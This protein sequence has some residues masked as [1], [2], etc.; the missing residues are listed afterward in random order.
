MVTPS[1]A[2]RATAR[3][4]A[5]R[6]RDTPDQ[7]HR[8]ALEEPMPASRTVIAAECVV[9]RLPTRPPTQAI[10]ICSDVRPR[11]LTGR[12]HRGCERPTQR[13]MRHHLSANERGAWD[14]LESFYKHGLGH[15]QGY[16][17]H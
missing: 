1:L 17:S 8:A 16:V 15:A 3:R 9:H 12:A 6:G 13:R 2:S 4:P 5:A 7:A 11:W 14:A 10:S